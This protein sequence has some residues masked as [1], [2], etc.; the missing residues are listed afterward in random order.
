V[1]SPLRRAR[2]T[3]APLAARWAAAA[4]VEPAFGEIP[5]PAG[6]PDDRAEWLRARLALRWTEVEVELLGWRERLLDALAALPVDTVIVTHYVAINVAAGAAS[7]DDRVVSVGPGHASL[8]ELD[9]VDGV[10]S[11]VAAPDG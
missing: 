7:G 11:L 8:T 2:E 10:L 1:T 3:A 5:V 4:R 9:V 6:A